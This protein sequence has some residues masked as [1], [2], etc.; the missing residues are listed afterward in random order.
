MYGKS[1]STAGIQQQRL[2]TSENLLN[3]IENTN[4]KRIFKKNCH[5]AS[6]KV[7]DTDF[8]YL[9]SNIIVC[10]VIC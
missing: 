10:G 1:E 7:T 3:L 9:A 8:A 4:E 2:S 6:D 5:S